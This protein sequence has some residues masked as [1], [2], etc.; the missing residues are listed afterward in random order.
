VDQNRPTVALV[1]TVVEVAIMLQPSIQ[2]V[3]G[4]LEVSTVALTVLLDQRDP[5]VVVVAE[6]QE[7]VQT[8]LQ[9]ME[10]RV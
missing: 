2:V 4:L 3:Q 6:L 5:V 8:D 7:L 9:E 10:V 1:E